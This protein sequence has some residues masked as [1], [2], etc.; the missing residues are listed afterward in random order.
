MDLSPNSR[1]SIDGVRWLVT[2]YYHLIYRL[3]GNAPQDTVTEPPI[4]CPT[5]GGPMQVVAFLP[6][7][8]ATFDTS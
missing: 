3:L 7:P 5:C 2:L 6:G 1:E 4:R 8:V